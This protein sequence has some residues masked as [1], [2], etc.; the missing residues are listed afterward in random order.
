MRRLFASWGRLNVIVVW[1]ALGLASATACSD[2]RIPAERRLPPDVTY[3]AAVRNVPRFSELARKTASGSLWQD[4]QFLDWPIDG[5]EVTLRQVRDPQLEIFRELI[6]NSYGIRADAIHQLIQGDSAAAAYHAEKLESNYVWMF[7]LGDKAAEIADKR[8]WLATWLRDETAR[9]TETT[10]GGTRCLTFESGK[11]PSTLQIHRLACFTKDSY[12]VVAT[13]VDLL[14]QVLE[15]WDGKHA[16]TLAGDERF[17]MIE[18]RSRAEA[19]GHEGMSIWYSPENHPGGFFEAPL[20]SDQFV[21]LTLQKNAHD[22]SDVCSECAMPRGGSRFLVQIAVG[23]L[24]QPATEG[25][26][27]VRRTTACRPAPKRA[28]SRAP[29][30]SKGESI[31]GDDSD[32]AEQDPWPRPAVLEQLLLP[33]SP[34]APPCWI[35]GNVQRLCGFCLHLRPFTRAAFPGQWGATIGSRRDILSEFQRF[36]R[37]GDR[38]GK[39]EY[40]TA[41]I[42]ALT[43]TSWLI[44]LPPEGNAKNEPTIMLAVAIRDEPQLQRILEQLVSAKL[45]V[46]SKETVAGQPVW[47]VV[48][49]R[50]WFW[51][52]KELSETRMTI[53]H[54]HL[55][56]CKSIEALRNMAEADTTQTAIADHPEYSA[57]MKRIPKSAW[58]VEFARAQTTAEFC[59]EHLSLSDTAPAAVNNNADVFAKYLLPE[60][61]YLEIDDTTVRKTH[62]ELRVAK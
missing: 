48:E 20:L 18:Q 8:E 5:R 12:L 34:L 57:L 41:L 2:E 59:R 55:L 36:V 58:V 52:R 17:R 44:D 16:E 42:E 51:T 10:R 56:L 31:P 33:E 26:D 30:G 11:P 54:G 50:G 47:Q 43:G 62:F 40:T 13:S 61:S 39:E 6:E 7:D 22:D 49:E 3:F 35:R 25:C 24:V 15:R 23:G 27:I 4:P 9:V 28:E 32:S 1:F 45:V 53:A 14:D 21:F 37:L 46:Q 38:K 60:A 29:A 19:G